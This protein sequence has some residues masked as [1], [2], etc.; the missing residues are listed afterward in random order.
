[1]ETH[2][3]LMRVLPLRQAPVDG[4]SLVL[5]LLT[6]KTLGPSVL[7]LPCRDAAD[8]IDA[9]PTDQ[10]PIY[11]GTSP[12]H[13]IAITDTL[14]ACV[15]GAFQTPVEHRAALFAYI[16]R[17]IHGYT[18]AIGTDSAIGTRCALETIGEAA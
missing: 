3:L 5:T 2:I 10:L 7:I 6:E 17:Q 1:M 14:G 13:E 18:T 11:A 8:N 9:E 15:R 4:Y 12:V 16:S